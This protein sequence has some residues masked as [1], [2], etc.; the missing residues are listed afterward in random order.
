MKI[1]IETLAEVGVIAVIRA[2]SA[3]A[4]VEGV[5][6]LVAGGVTG[7]EITYTT[8]GAAD[9]IRRVDVEFGDGVLLGAGTLRTPEQV[10][11]AAAAGARFLVSPGFAPDLAAAM[12]ATGLTTMIG[13]LTP[14]EVMTAEAHGADVV[15]VFPAGL[16]GPAVIRNLTGPFPTTPFMP[17]GGV[18]ASNVGD[19][20]SAG[21]VAVGAGGDLVSS[22]DLAVGRWD[23]VTERAAEFI[24]AYRTARSAVLTKEVRA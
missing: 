13:A 21:V 6:A 12:R 17:T 10:A 23:A 14:T 7:I 18:S 24:A 22:A 11:E 20:V 3:D 2:H 9:A 1:P 19:W 16:F 5:R 8:P 4:A 15:K